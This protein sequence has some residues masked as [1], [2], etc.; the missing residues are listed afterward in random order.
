MLD[1]RKLARSET[2]KSSSQLI[3]PTGIAT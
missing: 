2:L 3:M 1:R